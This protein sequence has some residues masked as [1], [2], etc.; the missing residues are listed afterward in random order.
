MVDEPM[1]EQMRA[2]M[3]GDADA[4]VWMFTSVELLSAIGRLDR[5]AEGLDDLIATIRAE[6]HGRDAQW[7]LVTHVEAVRRRAE[8]L[9]GVHPLSA[10]DAMQLAAAQVTSGDRP[11]TLTFVTL[12]KVLA[13]AAR[14]EGFRVVPAL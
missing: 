2:L 3:T 9:V 12:D 14:L 6:I 4:A 8:R 13:K 11:D 7:T 1:T 10:A 5:Q